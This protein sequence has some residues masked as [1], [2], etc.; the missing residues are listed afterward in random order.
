MRILVLG[1]GGTGG[2]FGGRLFQARCDVRFLVRPKR[3]AALRQHGLVIRSP[4]GD[5]T[6]PV[7]VVE[8]AQLSAEYDL[9]ILSCKA[10]DLDD[11]IQAV[12]PA[13]QRPGTTLLPLLN[14]LAHYAA[15]DAAFGRDAVLG[16]LCYISTTLNAA[17]EVVHMGRGASLT[18]GERDAPHANPDGRTTRIAAT[19]G[20]AAF[21]SR[22]STNIAA[23][24]W[25]KYAFLAA[26]AATTCL[27]RASI[28]DITSTPEGERITRQLIAECENVACAEGFPSSPAARESTQSTLTTPG[29]PFKSSMLRDI[30]AGNR[31]EADQ[32]V[33]DMLRRARARGIAA[34]LLEAAFAHLKAYESARERGR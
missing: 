34:P 32:I 11:A 25:E 24:M 31:V 6:L 18:F 19:F 13:M 15:L 21:E 10:Y 22:H 27:M 7:A 4:V 1:A 2:Y 20:P 8:P 26:A 17:G 5:A 30:E 9:V 14:G 3:A 29:S 23:A 33:G 16:G 28:G 12:R